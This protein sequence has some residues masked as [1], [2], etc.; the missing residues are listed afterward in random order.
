MY[1]K[2]WVIRNIKNKLT[3]R[4]IEIFRTTYFGSLLDVSNS[5][6]SGI[7]AHEILLRRVHTKNLY[8]EL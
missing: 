3:L 7:L 4:Q 2:L 5:Q 6:F 1:L 8:E